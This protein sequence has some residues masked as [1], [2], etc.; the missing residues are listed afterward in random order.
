MGHA[1][2]V[3]CLDNILKVGHGGMRVLVVRER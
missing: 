1:P 2:T 3:R